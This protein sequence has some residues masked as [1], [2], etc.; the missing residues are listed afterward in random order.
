[1]HK[2]RKPKEPQGSQSGSCKDYIKI[3]ENKNALSFGRQNDHN[4]GK[5]VLEQSK[6]R[7]YAKATE[8]N[9]KR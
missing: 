3:P 9:S 1:M 5:Q 2:V 7:K 8:N 6:P 4:F